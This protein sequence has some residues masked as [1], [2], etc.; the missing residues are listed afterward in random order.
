[1]EATKYTANIPIPHSAPNSWYYFETNM[2]NVTSFVSN[3]L[4]ICL[5]KT[6]VP[7]CSDYAYALH[8][9]CTPCGTGVVAVVS[10]ISRGTGNAFLS[11]L[12][13]AS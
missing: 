11:H 6:K 1:M 7:K 13:S 3:C 12:L 9:V 2:S 10:E 4:R 8:T 5:F